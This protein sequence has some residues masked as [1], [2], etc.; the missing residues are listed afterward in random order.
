M[1]DH[2]LEQERLSLDKPG[3]EC[4]VIGVYDFEGRDVASDI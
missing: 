2:Y 3:E 4:G 1:G